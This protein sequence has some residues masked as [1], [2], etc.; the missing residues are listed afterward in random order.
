MT[1]PLTAEQKEA[2]RLKREQERADAKLQ[3]TGADK[4]AKKAAKKASKPTKVKAAK[5][6]KPA[7]V[8]HNRGQVNEALVNIFSE[9]ARLDEDAK[10]IS[11]AKRDLRAKAKEEHHVSAANFNHEIKLQKMDQAARVD[12]ET[13]AQD[14]KDMLGIQ[15]SLNLAH[16]DDE[17]EGDGSYV[18]DP[19]SAAQRA[20]GLH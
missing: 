8:G 6:A 17:D 14:L 7:G 18:P 16:D 5:K 12:F 10:A 19:D 3:E 15:L 20:A 1:K 4:R 2:N 9:Y 11:R 13:G